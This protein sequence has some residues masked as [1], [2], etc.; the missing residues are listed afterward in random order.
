MIKNAGDQSKSCEDCSVLLNCTAVVVEKQEECDYLLFTKDMYS[1]GAAGAILLAL[2]LVILV[3][4]LVKMVAILNSCLK[5]PLST[6]V[7][8]VLNPSFKSPLATYLFS[9]VYILIG[10]GVTF[11]LQSSSVFTSTL[12]PMVGVGLVQVDNVYPLFLGSNIGTT[13]TSFLAALTQGSSGAVK[14][15]NALQGSF[16]HLFFNIF[17]ILLFYPIPFMR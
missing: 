8:K 9:Y 15:T 13:F 16:V 12:T 6:A 11:V 5:G 4:S 3:V 14:F 17:G 7:K 1:D 10:T 2:S